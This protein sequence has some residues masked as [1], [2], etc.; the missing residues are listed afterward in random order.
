MTKTYESKSF[1]PNGRLSYEEAA[2]LA[3]KAYRTGN[4][5]LYQLVDAGPDKVLFKDLKMLFRQVHSL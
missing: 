1:V 5:K 4:N 3:D 2:R